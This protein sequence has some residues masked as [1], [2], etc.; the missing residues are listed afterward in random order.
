MIKVSLIVPVYNTRD[1]VARCL[2]SILRQSLREI[3]VIVVDDCGSDDAM[4]IVLAF[5]QK[6]CA[7]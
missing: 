4:D 7:Y 1:Y 5:A 6:R 2:D 3:E